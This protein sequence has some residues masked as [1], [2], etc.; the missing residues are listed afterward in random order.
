MYFGVLFCV[1][2]SN[3]FVFALAPPDLKLTLVT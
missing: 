2:V 1:S 3:L